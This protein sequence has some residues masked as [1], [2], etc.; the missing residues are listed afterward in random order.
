MIAR[1][2]AALVG[3][4]LITIAIL[5]GMH[6]FA[7]NITARD[8]MRYFG[9]TDFVA[10]PDSRRPT[11]PPA[12]ATPPDRA[13]IDIRPSGDARVPVRMPQIDPDRVAPPPLVPEPN[14]GGAG[15][16]PTREP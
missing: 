15:Y 3:G 8:P 5:L 9:I 12:A 14:V 10:L 4:S 7:E 13:Q 2:L 1:Y 11:P 6:H 16:A